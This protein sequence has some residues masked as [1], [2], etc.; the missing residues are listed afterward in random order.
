[1]RSPARATS[2]TTALLLMACGGGDA[3]DSSASDSEASAPE[4]S[5]AGSPPSGTRV[6]AF[7]LSAPGVEVS[8]GLPTAAEL[9]LV[10]GCTPT[11]PL[12]IL[13]VRGSAGV[14]DENYFVF[15]ID[16]R[17]PVT[18]GQTGSVEL[19]KITWDNGVEVPEGL[20]EGVTAFVPNRLEGAGTLTVQAHSGVG[21][22]GHMAGTVE[23]TV[24]Y[25]DTGE[26]VP[27]EASFDISLAC[28]N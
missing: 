27:I 16:S 7:S 13:F 12:S 5:E 26:S 18:P 20:P 17:D 2:L 3:P 28:V 8:N 1:M 23:G 6:N 4:A 19:S 22:G 24:T 21:L 9:S 14:L 25:A 15:S 10:G 11:G